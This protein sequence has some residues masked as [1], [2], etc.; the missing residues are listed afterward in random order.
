MVGTALVLIG[1]DITLDIHLQYIAQ[2]TVHIL[3][4]YLI[5]SYLQNITLTKKFMSQQ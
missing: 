5:H 3:T 4:G 1:I 2:N